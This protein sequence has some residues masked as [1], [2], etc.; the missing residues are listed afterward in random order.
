MY[1][2]PKTKRYHF[3][4]VMK[5]QEPHNSSKYWIKSLVIR[6]IRNVFNSKVTNQVISYLYLPHENSP[7]L[8][9][10]MLILKDSSNWK[11]KLSLTEDAFVWGVTET[12]P[13]QK[14][15]IEAPASSILSLSL[16]LNLIWTNH[17]LHDNQSRTQP[18]TNSYSD[19]TLSHKYKTLCFDVIKSGCSSA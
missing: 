14:R 5:Q 12:I 16:H 13:T 4:Q 2:P 6:P 10:R 7:S 8:R 18:F 11:A 19:I 15:I 17:Q 3:V 9:Y 1:K